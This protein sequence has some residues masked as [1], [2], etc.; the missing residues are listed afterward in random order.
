MEFIKRHYEKL[1]LAGLLIMFIGSMVYL[2]GIM[3]ETGSIRLENL[4]IP[5]R[6]ADFQMPDVKDPQYNCNS[7]LFGM[8]RW[9]AS[10]PRAGSRYQK[11]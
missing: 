10:K 8:A 6:A 7:N 11:F 2:A 4:K 5:T 9:D 1:L 3:R